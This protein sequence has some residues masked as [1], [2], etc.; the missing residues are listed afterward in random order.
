MKIKEF[1]ENNSKEKFIEKS[2]FYI[3][4]TWGG[5]RFNLIFKFS[6]LFEVDIFNILN[7]K[8]YMHCTTM[9][10]LLRIMLIKSGL[11]EDEDIELK[12]TNS[13]YMAPHQYL[14]V[15]ISDEKFIF[16]DP[17]NYQFGI[18]FGKYGSGFD[19]LKVKSI[20]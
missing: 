17:W 13:W 6:R 20:R 18:D 10:F 11:F 4:K 3:V 2:F 8:G 1:L 12:I 15:K 7:T 14:K 9:N 19:S 5:N 16:L